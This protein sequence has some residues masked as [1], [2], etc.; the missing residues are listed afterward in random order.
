MN[1]SMSRVER[2]IWASIMLGAVVVAACLLMFFRIPEPTAKQVDGSE[3]AGG[4]GGISMGLTRLDSG[5]SDALLNEEATLF[6]PTP[7]FLPT[8]W[9]VGRN[10]LPNNLISN[11]DRVF[12]NYLPK[13][14]FGEFSLNLEFP[15]VV[16]IPDSSVNILLL[17]A[18]KHTF[19]G[20]G[21]T[22][23]SIQILPD[24]GAKVEVTSVTDG[25]QTSMTI[26]HHKGIQEIWQPMEFLLAVDA[27][28]L[29]G[30][31]ALTIRS[32][33]EQVDVFVQDFLVKTLRLGDRLPPGVYRV[34]VGP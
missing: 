22:D 29:I 13:F 3:G 20:F 12:E 34:C 6:D 15:A 30:P 10:T 14:T 21:R 17:L 31:P 4:N 25:H 27:A 24:R 33:D 23:S 32:G 28:G 18:P 9:N 16:Q 11:T 2:L 7:L 19:M 8:E 1:A 5:S 26:P